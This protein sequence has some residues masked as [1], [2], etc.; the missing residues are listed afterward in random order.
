MDASAVGCAAF[1]T[2]EDMPVSHK[3]WDSLQI[4]Q[5]STWRELHCVSF[6]IKNLGTSSLRL[7]CKVVTDSQAVSLIVDS[8]SMKE[9]LHQ[10]AVDIFHTAKE[11]NIEI[12]VGWIPRALNEKADF[13]SKIV[14]FDDWTVKDCYFHAVNSYWGPRSVY[15]FTSYKNHKIPR[16]YL[17]FFNAGSLVV[18][19]LAFNWAA[20]TCWLV[21]PVS[22]VKKCHLSRVLLSV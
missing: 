18:D 16:F 20:E 10:L 7:L 13:L 14:D 9:H 22:L 19:S 6:C 2:I 11:N 15:Y 4:K 17:K 21:P 3:N 8:D 1:I 12:E 5:S